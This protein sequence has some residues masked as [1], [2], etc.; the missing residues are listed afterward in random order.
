[1][2]DFKSSY[3]DKD[4]EGSKFLAKAKENP[5]VPAGMGFIQTSSNSTH[6]T[7][8]QVHLSFTTTP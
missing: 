5:F 8:Q 4:E 3:Y 7:R 2:N 1:M 6:P